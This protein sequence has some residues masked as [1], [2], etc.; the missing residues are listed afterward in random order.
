MFRSRRQTFWYIIGAFF[1]ISAGFVVISGAAFP[2]ALPILLVVAGAIM[3]AA[4]LLGF[5]PTFPAFA[6]FLAGVVALGLAASGPYGLYPYRETETYELT[7]AQAPNVK[8]ITVLCEVSTGTINVSFTSN[9]TQIYRVVFTKYYSIFHQPEVNFNYTI[10]NEELTVNASSSTATV[11]ITLN[12]NLKSSFNLTTTTGSIRVEVPATASKVEKMTLTTTTGE[13]WANITNTASLK[14]LVGKTTTGQVE[15]HIKSSLQNK[16]TTV[17]LSTTTGRVKLDL[18]ITNIESDITASTTTGTVN[19]QN[20]VGFTILSP[21]PNFHARTQDY[22]VS[23]FKKLD[24]S[25]NTTTGSVDISAY[26]K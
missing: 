21:A 18:N 8:E 26:H 16:D 11:D 6:V 2:N 24:I 23:T 20:I 17:Q 25:A 1:L 12:Q 4:G 9:E 10:K 7:R 14:N 15:V 19:A 13:V 22:G 3:I 5:I